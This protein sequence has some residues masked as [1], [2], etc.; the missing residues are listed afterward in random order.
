MPI[1]RPRF[2]RAIDS[3]FEHLGRLARYVSQD[4]SLNSPIDILVIARRPEELFEFGETRMHGELPQ[5][6][7]RKSEIDNPKRG[8]Q[9]HIGERAYRF[10]GEP[11]LE[12]HHLVWVVSA[13]SEFKLTHTDSVVSP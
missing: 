5:L 7:F 4:S 1:H 9:I 10:E 2:K 11:E 6:E 12:R 8:D 13:L 3:Q